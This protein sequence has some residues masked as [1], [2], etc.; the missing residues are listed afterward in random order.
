M[1]TVIPRSYIE[2]YSNALNGISDTAKASLV[3]ALES[4][5]YSRPVADIR[6]AVIAIMQAA[7]GA[8]TDVTAR[9]AADFYDGLRLRMAG[10]P[11][12]AV[13]DS[14]RKPEATE[15]TI[16]A[17][18]QVIVDGGDTD[19]FIRM[20]ADRIDYETRLAANQCIEYNAKND[21]KKPRWARIP[22]GVETCDF[23]IML[24]SR[25]FV[26]HSEETASHAHAHC[27]CRVV[28]SWDKSPLAQGYDPDKYYDMWKHPE[29]YENAQEQDFGIEFSLGGIKNADVVRREINNLANEYHTPLLAVSEA[30]SAMINE[31]MHEAGK[32]ELYT[33]TAVWLKNG[34]LQTANHEFGHT[35]WSSKREDDYKQG[36]FDE[37]EK[38]LKKLW[39]QYRKE[40]D[41]SKRISSYSTENIDEFFAD[42]FAAYKTGKG[43][44]KA[45]AGGDS[46]Y[47]QAIGELVDKYFKKK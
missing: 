12:G 1:A 15:N 24:A 29:K 2:E 36:G 28:P 18:I 38:E 44:D 30:P 22:T 11:M 32:A 23:C 10:E 8:S 13:A 16:R 31:R 39:R 5:D 43:S 33:G 46:P 3:A 9:L 27:D 26:Y 40:Q 34:N 41:L 14:M 6:N 17:F 21:P 42:G 47:A 25:G 7:C 20:C 19:E 45:G 4:V 37:F 35:L